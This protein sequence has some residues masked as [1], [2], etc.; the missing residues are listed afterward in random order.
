MKNSNQIITLMNLS[1]D[2]TLNLSSS[3]E[4]N[5]TPVVEELKIHKQF[6]INP[7][8]Q[9]MMDSIKDI[10]LNNTNNND[11]KTITNFKSYFSKR[12]E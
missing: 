12:K 8:P 2:E 5:I 11:Q 1:G 4:N 7:F 10:T 6:V 9:T 3:T